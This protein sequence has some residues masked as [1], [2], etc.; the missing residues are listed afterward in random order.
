[1]IPGWLNTDF[2]PTC[3]NVLYL[4][5][6]R[7]FPF[8]NG[9]LDYIFSEHLI[10][11]LEYDSAIHMLKEC[12]RVLKSNGRI[13]IATPDLSVLIGLYFCRDTERGRFYIDWI[14]RRLMPEVDTCREVFVIN[15]AF[16]AWGHK[17][18]YDRQTLIQTMRRS[19]FSEIEPYEPGMSND[20]NL[21]RLESHGKEIGSDE[22]NNY[23][24]FVLEGRPHG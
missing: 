2:E 23:E 17:F 20:E 5:V 8:E 22:I 19:G 11:H 9:T 7:P 13:R 4:D 14:V 6:S 21:Q 3:P 24:T 18:L 16:H 10:E 1:V 12:R 15:N